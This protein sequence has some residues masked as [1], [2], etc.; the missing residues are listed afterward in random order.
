MGYRAE[1]CELS[2]EV[3]KA[4]KRMHGWRKKRKGR[5]ALERIKVCQMRRNE[6]SRKGNER[7]G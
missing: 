2:K 1:D 5:K 4:E 3:V 7:Y 6:Q